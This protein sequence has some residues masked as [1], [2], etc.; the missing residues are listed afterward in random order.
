MDR[1]LKRIPE[2]VCKTVVLHH[3][4]IPVPMTGRERAVLT[5]AGDILKILVKRGA[6]LTLSGHRHTPWAWFLNNLA[7][8]TAGS[9]ST[10]KVRATIK[11]SYNIIKITDEFVE[12]D[13]KEVDGRRRLMTKY[14]RIKE[15]DYRLTNSNQ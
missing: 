11:Q 8:V 3:H 9:A 1:E 13:V 12:V 14:P 7:I 2:D 5:D 6:D 4:L 15:S 10:E